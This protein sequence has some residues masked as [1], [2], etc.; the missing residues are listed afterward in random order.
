MSSSQHPVALRLE[1]QVGGATKLLATVMGLPLLDGIFPALVLAGGV[2]SVAGILQV[3]LL[4]FGGSA[5]VAV[6]LAEMDGT[7]REQAGTVLTVGVGIIALAAVEAAF[8]PTI[9]SVL[10]TETFKRFA[11]LVMLAI[12]AKTASSRLGEYLPGP[13]V[14]V[15]LGLIAT[16]QPAGFNVEIVDYELV[17]RATAAAATGVTFALLVALT[18]PWLRGVVDIDRFRFGSAVALGVLPLSLLN[19]APGNAPLA[20]LAV[21]SL[22]AF[23]PNADAP[24]ADSNDQ[25]EGD[26]P[27]AAAEAMQS[28]ATDATGSA[29]TPGTDPDPAQAVAT[30]GSGGP[31][32]DAGYGYPGEEDDDEREPWL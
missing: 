31:D 9:E 27:T 20:V 18:S 21:T 24:D 6:I 3:G 32:S 25:S 10:D 13:G 23:D 16:F 19:L 4:V 2:N 26:D 12:A 22:L 15:G 11:A 29:T 30:D 17:L 1:R 14:I 8:A 28:E 5:T 7:P